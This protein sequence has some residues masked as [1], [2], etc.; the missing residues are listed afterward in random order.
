VVLVTIGMLAIVNSHYNDFTRLIEAQV[1]TALLGNENL[2]L[3]NLD[4][5][6]Q[7]PNRR[8]FFAQL[9]E[10]CTRATGNGQR[11]A[12]AILDLDG[13]KAVNDLY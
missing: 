9:N 1:K 12:V 6:T 7:I 3:A 13:F 8:K 5:L 11:F 2:R 4:S 10:I